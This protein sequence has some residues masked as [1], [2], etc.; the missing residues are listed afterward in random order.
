MIASNLTLTIII[1]IT[2]DRLVEQTYLST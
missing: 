2:S 1:T